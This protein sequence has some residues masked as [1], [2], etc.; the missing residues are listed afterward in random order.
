MSPP[1]VL[2]GECAALDAWLAS[3]PACIAARWYALGLWYVGSSSM[4]ESPCV[5][6]CRFHGLMWGVATSLPEWAVNAVITRQHLTL[7]RRYYQKLARAS[8]RSKTR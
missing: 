4:L 8:E 3:L 7:R 5:C 1:S 2:T 6:Q